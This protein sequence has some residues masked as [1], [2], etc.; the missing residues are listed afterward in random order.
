MAKRRED[1]IFLFFEYSGVLVITVP[2]HQRMKY[3][4]R[5]TLC[6]QHL[7]ELHHLPTI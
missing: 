2:W 4:Q 5:N 1:I 6:S 7:H 3:R